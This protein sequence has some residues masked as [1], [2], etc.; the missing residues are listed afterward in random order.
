M[1]KNL[2]V[3]AAVFFAGVLS[4]SCSKEN[5]AVEVENQEQEVN[6]IDQ[7]SVNYQVAHVNFVTPMEGAYG[8]FSK[9]KPTPSTPQEQLGSMLKELFASLSPMG[10]YKS[11]GKPVIIVNEGDTFRIGG[12]SFGAWIEFFYNS[13]AYSVN[14]RKWD[15]KESDDFVVEKIGGK[16]WFRIGIGSSRYLVN[17]SS[18][19]KLVAGVKLD[20]ILNLD[21]EVNILKY[22]GVNP[23]YLG[24][25]IKAEVNYFND[26]DYDGTFTFIDLQG[27][28]IVNPYDIDT[29]KEQETNRID[30]TL[31]GDESK[32][33]EMLA[34]TDENYVSGYAC[35][36]DY[37]DNKGS[38]S[39]TT[40]LKEGE[41]IEGW[42]GYVSLNSAVKAQKLFN[43]AVSM[44]L[45]NATPEQI[46]GIFSVSDAIE[47]V[48][49]IKMINKVELDFCKEGTDY[50]IGVKFPE[51]EENFQK[52]YDNRY[53]AQKCLF[54]AIGLFVDSK[55]EQARHILSK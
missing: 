22:N 20:D 48:H 37:T 30:M 19:D 24:F 15:S 44:K 4:I 49:F 43:D 51:D 46:A 10:G 31:E 23:F 47:V 16:L 12:F 6:I 21:S 42:L 53:K 33:E 55:D 27:K 36:L 7:E 18:F 32:K 54:D 38:L 40:S 13:L 50:V 11:F 45:H 35:T 8:D 14:P 3:I 2:I 5:L 34:I 28:K 1:K 26:Y 52:S 17:I 39:A 29:I 9:W 41:D 25:D